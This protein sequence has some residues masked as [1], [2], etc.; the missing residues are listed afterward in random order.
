MYSLR[1]S[2]PEIA[3]KYSVLF[4]SVESVLVSFCCIQEDLSLLFVFSFG[5]VYYI[6][7]YLESSKT[8]QQEQKNTQVK[9]KQ[10][11]NSIKIYVQRLLNHPVLS[12][13]IN[14]L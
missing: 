14:L 5:S 12:C 8:S 4:F 6:F 1:Q 7:N 10:A 9:S 11:S 13:D 3:D 2:V